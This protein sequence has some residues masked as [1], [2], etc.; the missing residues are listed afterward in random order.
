MNS[1]R[2]YHNIYSLSSFH[3]EV[4]EKVA[5]SELLVGFSCRIGMLC[6][7]VCLPFPS[8]TED[9]W[10]SIFPD[11]IMA[12]TILDRLAHHSHHIVIKG[13]LYRKNHRP[14]FTN[15]CKFEKG[16]VH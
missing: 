6:P 10:A 13:E 14:R 16:S 9:S 2:L 11:P 8:G 7:R 15:A 1:E 5:N 4:A 3:R 12:N